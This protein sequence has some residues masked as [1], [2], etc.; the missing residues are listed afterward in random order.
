MS[1]LKI[2]YMDNHLILFPISLEELEKAI[3][4]CVQ[5]CLKNH[6][7]K[8]APEREKPLS[9]PEA[10]EFLN[11]SVNSIYKLTRTKTIPHMKKGKSIYFLKEELIDWLKQGRKRTVD[12]IAAEAANYI[13][14]KRKKK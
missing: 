7:I 11:I 12:E 1:A 3:T 14:A 8:T 4:N 6:L 9:V 2:A 5:T 10:A 13:G